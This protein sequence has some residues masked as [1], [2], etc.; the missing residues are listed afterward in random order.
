MANIYSRFFILSESKGTTHDSLIK[1]DIALLTPY[2]G[3]N[4]VYTARA[5]MGIDPDAKGLIFGSF[6]EIGQIQSDSTI[7]CTIYP[8]PATSD[9]TIEISQNN[10]PITIKIVNM[11]GVAV[12]EKEMITTGNKAKLEVSGLSNGMYYC[13]VYVN[14]ERIEQQRLVISK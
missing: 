12:I 11:L 13:I 3:G 8:N 4:A 6:G 7:T 14:N 5:I 9:I 2:I 1:T 10:K